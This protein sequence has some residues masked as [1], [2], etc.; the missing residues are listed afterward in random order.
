[1]NHWVRPDSC[2]RWSS[3]PLTANTDWGPV[4]PQRLSGK[5][6]NGIEA[7]V[8]LTE[9]AEAFFTRH[10]YL[11]IER[12]SVPD[13]IKQSAEFQSLCPDSAI[14]MTKSLASVAVGVSNA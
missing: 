10:G 13:E 5:R 3:R 4:L 11:V 2:D 9:T 6:A 7:L 8:L 14:C 12:E 1:M